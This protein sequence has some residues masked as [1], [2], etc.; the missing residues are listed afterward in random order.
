MRLSKEDAMLLTRGIKGMPHVEVQN[1]ETTMKKTYCFDDVLLTPRYSEIESRSEV[2]LRSHLK[3]EDFLELP[4]IS[5]PMDTVTESSMASAMHHAGGLGI[6]HRYNSIEE[7]AALVSEASG[8]NVG[9][10]IGVTGDYLDRATALYDAG[11]RILCLD[12]A[13]GHHILMQQALIKLRDIFGDSVHLMAGNVATLEAFD[14]LASWGADS[15]RV[16]IG[17]G[18]IC[19]TRIVTG[20]GIPTFQSVLECSNTSYDAES[21]IQEIW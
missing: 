2:S 7:Q 1:K 8:C 4:I 12:I 13:H 5:S 17:G 9:A 11:A 3:G 18:S 16:G 6:V 20:H 10:A 15:I 14:D 19:S 21:R